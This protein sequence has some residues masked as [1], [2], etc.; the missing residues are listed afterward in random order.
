VKLR[1]EYE[2]GGEEE[3]ALPRILQRRASFYHYVGHPFVT[4][5]AMTGVSLGESIVAFP[6]SPS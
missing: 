4:G 1:R 2:D 3:H 6:F 5:L